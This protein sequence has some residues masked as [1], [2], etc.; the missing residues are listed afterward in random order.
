MS[1]DLKKP[2][3]ACPFLR[4]SPIRLTKKRAAEIIKNQLDWSGGGFPCHKTVDYCSKDTVDRGQGCKPF[5]E[6]HRTNREQQCA[7][8][9]IFTEKHG[10]NNQMM[11]IAGRL[12]LYKPD[13]LMADKESVESVFDTK[14]EMLK[15]H[16]LK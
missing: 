8:A 1:H 2:C 5:C 12:G 15:F 7:G 13:E 9:L 10:H 4:D 11:R 16:R 14:A 3:D 6:G